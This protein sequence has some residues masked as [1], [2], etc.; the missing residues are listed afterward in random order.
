MPC[1]RS[2]PG[3]TASHLPGLSSAVCTRCGRLIYRNRCCRISFY[4]I[5]VMLCI[6][7]MNDEKT[8]SASACHSDICVQRDDAGAGKNESA[9][10]SALVCA[11]FGKRALRGYSVSQS[12]GDNS[13]L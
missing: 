8:V 10:Q 3:C 4:R 11:R 9:G 5:E 12:G 2:L 7:R 1:H 6:Q 13:S